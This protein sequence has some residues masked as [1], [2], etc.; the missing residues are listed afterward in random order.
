MTVQ[1]KEVKFQGMKNGLKFHETF[2]QS[3]LKFHKVSASF[4]K[5]Q[6]QNY[7]IEILENFSKM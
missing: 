4:T 5:F 7:H 6:Q 3:F 1:P 2:K